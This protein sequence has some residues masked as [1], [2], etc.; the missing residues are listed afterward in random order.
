MS[1]RKLEEEDLEIENGQFASRPDGIGFVINEPFASGVIYR[2]VMAAW[3][4]LALAFPQLQ[5]SIP[6]QSQPA[7]SLRP[8]DAATRWAILVFV[9][10]FLGTLGYNLYLR[11]RPCRVRKCCAPDAR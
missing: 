8:Q 11:W 5:D 2:A 7:D 4:F 3:I 9:L 1:G 6:G 10:G